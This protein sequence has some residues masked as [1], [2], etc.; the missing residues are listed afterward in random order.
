MKNVKIICAYTAS[1]GFVI[2]SKSVNINKEF[3][4]DPFEFKINERDNY[5]YNTI[6]K[7]QEPKSKFIG[8]PRN[9]YKR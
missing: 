5:D 4:Q 8:K 2:V 7:N 9:N 3:E 6:L 1:V